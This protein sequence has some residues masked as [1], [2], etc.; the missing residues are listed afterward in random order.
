MIFKHILF[1]I[2]IQYVHAENNTNTTNTTAAAVTTTTPTTTTTTAATTTIGSTTT[3]VFTTTSGSITS[4]PTTTTLEPVLSTTT[5]VPVV[6]TTTTNITNSSI[7][8]CSLNPSNTMCKICIGESCKIF[9]KS[10]QETFRGIIITISILTLLV[11]TGC[12][13]YYIFFEYPKKY[14]RILEFELQDVEFSD[15][16]SEPE[17]VKNNSGIDV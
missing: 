3:N 12:I 9:T 16:D 7:P 13:I 8:G 10:E 2:L 4:G 14:K 15:D 17:Y 1:I 11:T 6:E 5:S